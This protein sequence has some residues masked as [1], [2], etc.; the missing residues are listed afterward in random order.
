M[1]KTCRTRVLALCLGLGVGAIADSAEAVEGAKSLYVLGRRG[2]L[3]GLIPKPGW[4]FTNDVYYYNAG[5][6]NLTPF[7]DRVAGDINVNALVNI[8]QFTWVTDQVFEN[9]RVALGLVV[10]YGHVKTD[11]TVTATLPSGNAARVNAED[12]V[13]GFGDPTLAAS[14]GWHHRDGQDFRAWSLY[15]AVF[16]PVGDYQKGRLANIGANHWGVDL[17]SA[18]TLGNFDTGRELS[19]TVGFTF[20]AKNPDTDYRSG[21][22]FHIEAA[23]TQH[24]PKGWSVG[25]VSY[26]YQQ[27][28]G[29]SG[30]GATLGDFKGRVASIGPEVGYSFKAADRTIG[31]NLRWYHEFAAQNRVEGN[32]VYLTLALPLQPD[33]AK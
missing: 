10:P 29:D 8:A 28:T 9:G 21:T 3:A 13:T 11:G 5:R 7:G 6:S 24:L 16:I 30:P 2:A 23:Y 31:L 12:S 4:Y 25:L 19:G 20:N 26:F 15:T 33:P 17:G 27:L 32:A 22:E 14:M 1:R 18:F